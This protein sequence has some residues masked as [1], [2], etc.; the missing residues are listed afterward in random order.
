[1]G[2]KVLSNTDVMGSTSRD[3]LRRTLISTVGSPV[4]ASGTIPDF[5]VLWRVFCFVFTCY[6]HAYS[7]LNLFLKI[8]TNKPIKIFLN[9]YKPRGFSPEIVRAAANFGS[10]LGLT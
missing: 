9:K 10:I 6:M 3:L 1:M 2:L 5:F 7:I 4:Y 8:K